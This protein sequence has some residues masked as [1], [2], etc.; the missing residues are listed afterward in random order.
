YTGSCSLTFKTFLKESMRLIYT[1]DRDVNKFPK[2]NINP[3]NN[4]SQNGHNFLTNQIFKNPDSQINIIKE[5]LNLLKSQDNYDLLY[6]ILKENNDSEAF[7]LKCIKE[8]SLSDEVSKAINPEQLINIWD[9]IINNFNDDELNLLSKRMVNGIQILDYLQN[10][11]FD[12]DLECLYLY[13][14]NND[15]INNKKFVRW[16]VDNIKNIEKSKW[17]EELLDECC[18]ID[19]IIN[20]QKNKIKIGLETNFLDALIEHGIASMDGNAKFEQFNSSD[21]EII[22]TALKEDYQKKSLRNRLITH[23]ES[24][25]GII[26]KLFYDIYGKEIS[27]MEIIKNDN[28]IIINLFT[29]ILV[30]RDLNGLK[31][32]LNLITKNPSIFRGYKPAYAVKDFKDR[33]KSAC[34]SD[35]NDEASQYIRQISKILRMKI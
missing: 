5:F 15:G 21:W 30:N 11:E 6:V 34:Q 20:L 24:R 18:L 9:K 23:A 7:I 17:V 8:L 27:D 26:N 2:A 16:L 33:I 28:K 22:I 4:N 25:N 1:I 14:L 10:Q 35:S 32:L 29:P 12:V 31:W 3:V 13:L 19:I